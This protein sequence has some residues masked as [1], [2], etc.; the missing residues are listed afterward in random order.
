MEQFEIWYLCRTSLI[1]HLYLSA[2][3]QATVRSTS[4]TARQARPYGS[5]R[6]IQVRHRDRH[7][8]TGH[9]RSFRYVTE[10]GTPIRVMSCHSGMSETGTSIW[11]M[12]GH[13]G[14]S[15]RR[16]RPYGSCRVI[17]VRH[18][19]RHAHMGH[20][21]SLRYFTETGTSIQVML[22]HSGMSQ[23]QACP[24]GS[25]RAIQVRH[26][27]RHAHTGHVGSLRYVTETGTS[28]QVMSGHSGTSQRQACPYESCRVTQVHHRDRHALTGHVGSFRYVTETGTPIRVSCSKVVLNVL[29][30]IYLTLG[31]TYHCRRTLNRLCLT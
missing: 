27:D 24:Y 11:V 13:S 31:K 16:A 2:A 6:A 28:I 15:Q 29:K 26:R 20:V 18:R 19:A 17:Q 8:H 14:T 5:C 7:A 25:C 12:S 23:R 10:T 30:N 21:G 4:Q 1:S 3:V 9:V 22:G